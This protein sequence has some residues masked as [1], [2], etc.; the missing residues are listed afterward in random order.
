ME[1]ECFKDSLRVVSEKFPDCI[2][3]F[4]SNWYLDRWDYFAVAIA[5][6]AAIIAW[7]TYTSQKKTESNT[8]Q[9]TEE[10]QFDLLIDYIRHFYA[11]LIVIKAMYF[12][13]AD[14][15]FG[16]PKDLTDIK[17]FLYPRLR[18]HYPSE[19]HLMKLAMDTEAL[20]PEVFVHS[21][22][23]YNEIHNLLLLI[24]NYN[25]ETAVTEIHVSSPDVGARTKDRDLNTLMFK[26]NLFCKKFL[27]K[28]DSLSWYKKS[29]WQK[30]CLYIS[31]KVGISFLTQYIEKRRQ[32][33]HDE[34]LSALRVKIHGA[35]L[36]ESI[37]RSSLS[38]DEKKLK[39]YDAVALI[40]DRLE[41]LSSDKD[42][43]IN[44]FTKEEMASNKFCELFFAEEADQFWA[45]LNSNIYHE[46][47][48]KNSQ[49]FDKIA[50]LTFDPNDED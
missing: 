23:K 34:R 8:M 39:P 45:V 31:R 26:Q 25:I 19:E 38:E 35:V 6:V 22:E 13:L 9:V 33:K 46:L 10:G 11:N 32:S 41:K 16:Y 36:N 18:T 43:P 40:K 12:K 21:T 14:L 27:Q 49:G 48:G 4:A 24:R 3:A 20:H 44:Y 42:A 29:M 50:I 5:V 17:K 2:Y 7:F 37:M 15:P 1:C 30:F 28:I 47:T